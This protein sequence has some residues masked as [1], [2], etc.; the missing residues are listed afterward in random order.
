MDLPSQYTECTGIYPLNNS[1]IDTGIVA[2]SNLKVN[3]LFGFPRA[4]TGYLFGARNTNSTSSIGQFGF[5][6]ALNAT[7]YW[8]FGNTRTS[9]NQSAQTTPMGSLAPA[10]SHFFNDGNYMELYRGGEQIVIPSTSNV[11]SFANGNRTIHL[12]GL[13]NAGTNTWCQAWLFGFKI[14]DNG[15]VH[16]FVPCYDSDTSKYG[17]YDT[18]DSSFKPLENAQDL[19]LISVRSDG[20]GE[21]KFSTLFGESSATE[22]YAY[23][24]S[25][26]YAD[27]PGM[28]AVKLI[29]RPKQGYV[30]KNW[31]L[32]TS[33]YTEIISTEEEFYYLP[34][35]DSL[36]RANFV[37]ETEMSYD[38]NYTG[39]ALLYGAGEFSGTISS[40]LVLPSLRND[41]F[42]KIKSGTIKKDSLQKSTSTFV[43]EEVSSALQTNTPI[44]IFSPKGKCVYEGIVWNIEENKI[45]C[46]EPLA[47]FDEDY[48]LK[49]SAA[50]NHDIRFDYMSNML[51]LTSGNHGVTSANCDY[52]DSRKTNNLVF[53]Y[54]YTPA[55]EY[56]LKY[57]PSKVAISETEIV[58][59]EEYLLERFAEFGIYVS[60]KL[61]K[62]TRSYYDGTQSISYTRHLMNLSLPY[63]FETEPIYVSDNVENITDVSIT[64]EDSEY[65]VLGIYNSNGS[66]L[67]NFYT[68]DNNGE[69]LKY[70]NLSSAYP[71]MTH[72]KDTI[73][74]NKYKVKLVLSDEKPETLIYQYLTNAKYSHKI[75]FNLGLDGSLFNIDS[76]KIGRLAKFYYQDKLY[77]SVVTA[78]EYSIKEGTNTIDNVKVTLGNVRVSLT[79]KLNKK[80]K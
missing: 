78:L 30:F 16:N 35:Y 39:L 42:V 34:T 58:N 2:S 9:I 5:Y 7:S 70:Q 33:G 66:T 4:S 80:K 61:A 41:V 14:D 49:S 6:Q 53:D 48:V 77:D 52:L 56:P 46:R 44:F 3:A 18:F 45:T 64:T 13:N 76:F 75:T 71:N 55:L 15:D 24:A 8:C 19:Y 68:L 20:N 22:V 12:F 40:P 21:A 51:S 63:I 60:S 28:G 74:F 17:V 38:L 29:A 79:A 54:A 23:N 27:M 31:T 11:T 36:V 32:E 10:Y 25:D 47:M 65:T 26:N 72:L 37:K 59:L 69:V 1:F 43:L 62:E 73:G 67:K 50:S 57:V